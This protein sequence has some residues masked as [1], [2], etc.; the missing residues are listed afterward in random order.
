L[1]LQ[2]KINAAKTL[3]TLSK[4]PKVCRGH[5]AKKLTEFFDQNMLQHIDLEQGLFDWMIPCSRIS[6]PILCFISFSSTANRLPFAYE[7]ALEPLP[8]QGINQ[9][10][11]DFALF[12]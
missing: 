8:V 3:K 2:S 11:Y 12:L 1:L 7:N 4:P 9:Q 5:V 6:A 10:K